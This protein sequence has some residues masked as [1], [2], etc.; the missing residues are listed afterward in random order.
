MPLADGDHRYRSLGGEPLGVAHQ[1]AIDHDVAHHDHSA[2][3]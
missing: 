2:S 3:L 1:I